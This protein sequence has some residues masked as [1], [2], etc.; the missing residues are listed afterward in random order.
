M[1]IKVHM[2]DHTHPC[3]YLCVYT[4]RDKVFA[5]V[6]QNELYVLQTY[7]SL[8]S[9]KECSII[10]IVITEIVSMANYPRGFD[11]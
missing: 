3:Y 4:K 10:V 7:L 9:N 11:C 8:F 2:V 5:L 6:R 1:K